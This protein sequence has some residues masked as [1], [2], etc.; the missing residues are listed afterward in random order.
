MQ[1][2]KTESA[3]G[4]RGASFKWNLEERSR[5]VRTRKGGFEAAAKRFE[6]PQAPVIS[7]SLRLRSKAQVALLLLLRL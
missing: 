7:P 5:I 2:S 3:I 4:A 1:N 6:P